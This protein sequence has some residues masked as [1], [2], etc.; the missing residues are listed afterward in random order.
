[1]S[2]SG[3]TTHAKI[4]AKKNELFH[5]ETGELLRSEMKKNSKESNIIKEN[6]EQKKLVPDEIIESL[7]SRKIDEKIESRGIIFDGFPGNT[8]QAKFLRDILEEKGTK[9]HYIFM[10]SVDDQTA[11]KRI[12]EKDRNNGMNLQMMNEMIKSQKTNI[13]DV[14]D[15]YTYVLKNK[16]FI[17]N[18]SDST[19]LVQDAIEIIIKD[20]KSIIS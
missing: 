13:D 17:F 14:K 9:L 7:I 4:L 5:L 19:E 12:K 10:L 1:M 11:K 2:G 3:K 16:P 8:D 15:Y 18:S 20:Q 6:L